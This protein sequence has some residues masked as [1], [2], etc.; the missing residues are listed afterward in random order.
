MAVK[1]DDTVIEEAKALA[2]FPYL[3]EFDPEAATTAVREVVKE[4]GS[5]VGPESL[6]QNVFL[7]LGWDKAAD[8]GEGAG[9]G[10]DEEDEDEEA[11]AAREAAA[12]AAA[13]PPVVSNNAMDVWK[14]LVGP[15]EAAEA[16]VRAVMA[17]MA[18]RLRG[19][20][21]PQLR[22]ATGVMEGEG[23][24]GLSEA[25]LWAAI[26]ACA[27]RPL[28][29]VQLTHLRRL[30]RTAETWLPALPEEEEAAEEEEGAAEAMAAAKQALEEAKAGP[31]R[32]TSE[33]WLGLL[34]EDEFAASL[35]LPEV[36]VPK[37]DAPEGGADEDAE[38]EDE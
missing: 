5:P 31:R 28:E 34:A 18:V 10:E 30:W 27:P 21:E 9:A 33:S 24:T 14:V 29:G 17:R 2:R 13:A 19:Y 26:T 1:V 38:D 25:D 6:L 11:K 32:V 15:D 4:A 35:L 12:A 3:A 37:E 7:K 36:E 20:G 16:D 8:E 22:F 23:G